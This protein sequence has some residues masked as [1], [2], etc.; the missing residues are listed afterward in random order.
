MSFQI[1]TPSTYSSRILGI[2]GNLENIES[3]QMTYTPQLILS[4]F[5]GQDIPRFLGSSTTSLKGG[6]LSCQSMNLLTLLL[7]LSSSSAH[8]GGSWEARRDGLTGCRNGL[9]GLR[10][11]LRSLPVWVIAS[12]R[13]RYVRRLD[14]RADR[15]GL[16]VVVVVLVV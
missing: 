5:S 16:V 8:G 13:E 9:Q 1:T 11:G 3:S 14:D 12:E 15:I 6:T 10:L 4:S 2:R 7:G